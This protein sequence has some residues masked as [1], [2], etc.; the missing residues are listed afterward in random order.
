M[1]VI[2]G[3]CTTSAILTCV[4]RVCK[5]RGLVVPEITLKVPNCSFLHS[6]SS[7]LEATF[8]RHRVQSVRAMRRRARRWRVTATGVLFIVLATVIYAFEFKGRP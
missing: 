7:D 8:Y 6:Q 5:S 1:G 3:F 4:I 2:L